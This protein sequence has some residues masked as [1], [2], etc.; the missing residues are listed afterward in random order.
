VQQ[1]AASGALKGDAESPLATRLRR[2]HQCCCCCIREIK[3]EA[4]KLFSGRK[5]RQQ[6]QAAAASARRQTDLTQELHTLLSNT[7]LN[8]YSLNSHLGEFVGEGKMTRKVWQNTIFA[9]PIY[10]KKE[11]SGEEELTK[12]EENGPN[13]PSSHACLPWTEKHAELALKNS[14]LLFDL[15]RR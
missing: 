7:K 12:L 13:L 1:A 14:R 4:K 10:C 8:N 9:N 3:S 15:R 11:T 2:R 5:R 6:K